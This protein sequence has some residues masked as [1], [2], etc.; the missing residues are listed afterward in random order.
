MLLF[1]DIETTGLVPEDD[2]ILEVGFM[3]T[4]DDLEVTDEISAVIHLPRLEYIADGE[5][6]PYWEP[7]FG[8]KKVVVD[9]H[10]AS[11]LWSDV[12]RSSF[13]AQMVENMMVTW[14]MDHTKGEKLPLIG[15][16][17]GFDRE[18]LRIQ[19]PR[20]HEMFD[21]HSGD[22]SAIKLFSNK[23]SPISPGDW[24]LNEKKH[25]SIPDMHDTLRE[26]QLFKSAYFDI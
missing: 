18:V 11:G 1:A 4:T 12:H 5:G 23:W 16:T 13:T 14:L 9:M 17:I 26:L 6:G 22:V 24:P 25:R 7:P 8:I 20:L 3:I 10:N 15:S 21:Y 19:M 2:L